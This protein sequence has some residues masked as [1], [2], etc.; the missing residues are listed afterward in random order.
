MYSKAILEGKTLTELK[1][2]AKGMNISRVNHLSEQELIYKILDF[3]AS[4]PPEEDL[5]KENNASQTK[6]VE[7]VLAK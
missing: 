3:Q 4:N 6:D 1:E 5:Q 7:D 2:I